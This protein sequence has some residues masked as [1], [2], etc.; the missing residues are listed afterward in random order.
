MLFVIYF[1]F[2]KYKCKL[3]FI[4]YLEF[5]KHA[6]SSFSEYKPQQE[7]SVQAML[8]EPENS[9]DDK[10][11]DDEVCLLPGEKGTSK[12]IMSFQ[13]KDWQEVVPDELEQVNENNTIKF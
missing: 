4:N 11:D 9:N 1:F 6:V 5:Y 8:V 13:N 3:N 2:V 7:V 12:E 10:D